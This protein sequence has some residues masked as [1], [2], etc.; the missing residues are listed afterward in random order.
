[1][2]P[3]AL[4][5]TNN[6]VTRCLQR[7]IKPP[8]PVTTNQSTSENQEKQVTTISTNQSTS[9]HQEKQA[10]LIDC[11]INA[12]KNQLFGVDELVLELDLKVSR[13]A[14]VANKRYCKG[15]GSELEVGTG[16]A[17]G[18]GGRRCMPPIS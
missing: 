2:Y 11:T 16:D 8:T 7:T 15:L 5:R 13:S 14:R 10:S 9:A 4:K 1:M 12:I 6:R 3:H 17:V 18:G